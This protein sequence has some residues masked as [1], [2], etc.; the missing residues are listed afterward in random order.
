LCA[1]QAAQ[2]YA[3]TQ[4]NTNLQPIKAAQNLIA[5]TYNNNPSALA[6][7]PGFNTM[8]N[9]VKPGYLGQSNSPTSQASAQPVLGG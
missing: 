5:S 9:K 6:S 7:L 8:M 1:E 2:P 4:S 3:T